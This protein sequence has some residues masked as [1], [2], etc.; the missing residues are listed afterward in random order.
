MKNLIILAMFSSLFMV[1]CETEEAISL[2]GVVRNYI[3][4]ET[5]DSAR[6]YIFDKRPFLTTC[7]GV[8]EETF[9]DKNGLFK[10]DYI[11]FCGSYLGVDVD[12]LHGFN[13]LRHH[14]L[15]VN[16]YPDSLSAIYRE[17]HFQHDDYYVKKSEKNMLVEI[18]PYL[19]ITFVPKENDTLSLEYIHIPE[20]DLKIDSL[21]IY[22]PSYYLYLKKFEGSTDIFIKHHNKAVIKQRIDY[23]YFN[24]GFHRIDVEI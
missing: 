23:D 21:P 19:Y 18:Q 7:Q 11:E 10:I 24:E 22:R 2:S 1:S 20:F 13:N 9:T 12:N 17:G 14:R 6:V 16:G 5:I 3:T 8:S 15:V 4:K